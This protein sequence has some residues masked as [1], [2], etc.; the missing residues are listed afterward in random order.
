MAFFIIKSTYHLH[1]NML[2]INIGETSQPLDQLGV[3]KFV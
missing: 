2:A 1:K 3:W